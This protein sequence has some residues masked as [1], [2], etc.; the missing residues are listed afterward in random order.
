MELI[1]VSIG[2]LSKNPLWN[3]RMPVRPSHATT[4]LIR[5]A[6]GE[7]SGT[8]EA[9]ILIDPS[10]P[11]DVLDSRLFEHAGIHADAITHVF[12]TNWRPIHRRG[13]TKFPRATW[14]MHPTEIESATAALDRAAEHLADQAA[15]GAHGPS[16]DAQDVIRQERT[17]LERVTPAPDELADNVQLF[18]LFGYTQGQ[19]G[20]I[21]AEPTLTTVIAGD[22]V[23]THGH[24]VA[25]QVFPDCFDL[26]KAKESL[27]EL[28][29]VADL[30]VPGHGNLFVTPRGTGR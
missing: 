26:D 13:L 28:Y 27:V 7:N 10:L 22:A 1:I 3:E 16:G 8:K 4:T 20:I 21:V 9:L 12:L 17:L 24:F 19:C 2:S 30:I 25:G 6:G 18:P 11:G 5:A 29:E 23:P 15:S 14:W